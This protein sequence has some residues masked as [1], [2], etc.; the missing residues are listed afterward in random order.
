MLYSLFIILLN[1]FLIK[2]NL[3]LDF[4]NMNFNCRKKRY[5]LKNLYSG[6]NFDH[7]RSNLLY[8]YF[9]DCCIVQIQFNQFFVILFIEIDCNLYLFER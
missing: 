4:W 1:D 2:V 7:L 3:P 9:L 5:L 8:T 6:K